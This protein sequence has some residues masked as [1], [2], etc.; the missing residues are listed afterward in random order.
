M[1]WLLDTN[2]WLRA[3]TEP[4]K[5]S[6]A[7][8]A[9]LAAP[10]NSPFALSAMS[11]WEVATKFRKRSDELG[12]GMPLN[13]WLAVALRPTFVRVFPVDAEIARLSNDL[14]DAFHEDPADRL[15]V[16]TAIRH[17]LTLL[18]SDGRILAYSHVKT[19]DTR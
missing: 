17:E 8:L 10:E 7:A 1:I 12:L 15:I 5:L 18:T 9:I 11:V 6:R 19:F 2:A 13:D 3:V 14:P 4:E 16:A